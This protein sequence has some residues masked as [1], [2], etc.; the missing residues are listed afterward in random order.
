MT[1]CQHLRWEATRPRWTH[2]GRSSSGWASWREHSENLPSSSS[3][4]QS[5]WEMFLRAHCYLAK[6]NREVLRLHAASSFYVLLA[7][8]S[9]SSPFKAG[10]VSVLEGSGGRWVVLLLQ[11]LQVQCRET[12]QIRG[13]PQFQV[14]C[15]RHSKDLVFYYNL[16]LSHYL[17]CHFR[18]LFQSVHLDISFITS[19][20]RLWFALFKLTSSPLSF[21]FIFTI[22]V[23][24]KLVRPCARRCGFRGGYAAHWGGDGDAVASW[25]LLPTLLMCA[26]GRCQATP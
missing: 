1:Y 4:S 13:F 22:C 2:V 24:C 23:S 20:Q 8:T 5:K 26:C 7:P 25:A 12:S 17:S 18:V 10:V 14:L 9:T 3:R 21:P 19:R 11:M 15:S 6:K 16:P